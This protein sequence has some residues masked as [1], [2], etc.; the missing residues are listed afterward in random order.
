MRIVL[1]GCGRVA[2]HYRTILNDPKLADVQVVGVCDVDASKRM[3]FASHFRAF[4]S[5][6]IEECVAQANPNL[7]VVATPSGLHVWRRVSEQIQSS[8]STAE[9]GC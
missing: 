4:E 2:N 6:N 7:V 1:V 5:A 8:G 3:D 9:V